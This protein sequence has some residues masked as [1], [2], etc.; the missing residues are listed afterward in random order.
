MRNHYLAAFAVLG[1]ARLPY[2]HSRSSD[3][4]RI[5]NEE[6]HKRPTDICSDDV[7]LDWLVSDFAP[8]MGVEIILGRFGRSINS[9]FFTNHGENPS[10]WRTCSVVKQNCNSAKNE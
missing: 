10:G 3:A 5:I 6:I 8:L 9:S 1:R 2:L 7:A 4:D